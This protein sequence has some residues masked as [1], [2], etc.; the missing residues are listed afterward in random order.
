MTVTGSNLVVESA[1]SAAD[2]KL[3]KPGGH[4]AIHVPDTGL[5][6]TGTVTQ[7]ATTPGTNGVDPQRYYVEVTPDNLDVGLA[8]AS[9]VQTISVSTTQGD[10]LAL[11][12]AALSMASDGTTRVQVLNPGAP[13]RF[14]TV[15]PGL[16]AKGLVAV[17]AVQGDLNPGDL[18]VVGANQTNAKGAA[19]GK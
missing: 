3:V 4:V 8:G 18:V 6:A 19:R 10:V 13:V 5:D 15:E 1:L 2:A 11:P 16:A 12:V 14:V 17:T 9:V 7:I